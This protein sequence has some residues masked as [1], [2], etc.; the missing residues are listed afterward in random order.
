MKN[1]RQTFFFPN[2][3][4]CYSEIQSFDYDFETSVGAWQVNCKKIRC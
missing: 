4:L 1:L 2:N 3:P